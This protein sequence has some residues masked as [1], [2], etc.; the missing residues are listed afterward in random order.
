MSIKTVKLLWK[1]FKSKK[2]QLVINRYWGKIQ[3]SMNSCFEC[4]FHG[5]PVTDR[6]IW[7]HVMIGIKYCDLFKKTCFP[8]YNGSFLTI[9]INH[10]LYISKF[11]YF[12]FDKQ[13]MQNLRD[14]I[15]IL[16]N[17]HSFLL[18]CVQTCEFHLLL[19][20]FSSTNIDF[21]D[22]VTLKTLVP[23]YLHLSVSSGVENVYLSSSKAWTLKNLSTGFAE[24]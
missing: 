23:Q 10:T 4:Y 21:L 17:S 15:M 12:V 22:K 13:E 1:N 6:H 14:F 24:L 11:I 18:R 20:L 9:K 19:W 16:P 5:L 8:K 3:I 7:P 2:L